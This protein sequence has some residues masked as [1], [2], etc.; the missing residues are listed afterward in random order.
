M[1]F[2]DNYKI[3]KKDALIVFAASTLGYEAFSK[4]LR[5]VSFDHSKY[6]YDYKYSKSGPFWGELKN[7][8]SLKHLIN[9]V[10]NY[11]NLAWRKIHAKYSKI[12]YF[13]ITKILKKNFNKT[14]IKR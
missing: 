6:H 9:K 11:D 10:L 8:R 5:C 1:K 4:G 2:F 12:Y 14:I 13:L 7:F 3:M